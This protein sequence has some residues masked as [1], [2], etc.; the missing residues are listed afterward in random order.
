MKRTGPYPLCR[1]LI[2]LLIVCVLITAAGCF[3]EVVETR[4]DLPDI[5]WPQ[6]P[7]VPR[8][9]F[10]NAISNPEDFDIREGL[11]ARIW[12]FLKGKVR[13][14]IIKPYGI[15]TDSE[16]RLY[17][18]DNF[19]RCVHVFH[20][21]NNEYYIFPQGGVE[22]LSPIGIA[23]DKN[24]TIYVSD[25]RDQVVKLFKNRGK[26]FFREIG[27]G[28]L[29]RPTGLAYNAV[30][31][32]LL[33]VDTKYSEII[34]YDIETFKY[35]GTFGGM[36]AA[37][38]SFNNPTHIYTDRAGQIY[39]SDSLNFR[40]QVFRHDGTFVRSFGKGGDG[41]G[42]FSRPKGVAADSDGNI[43]V[44]D[45]LF[46][47]VQIFNQQGELLMD[48]GKTGSGY[49]EFWL[50]SGIFIDGKDR[51]YVSDSYN[52]RVQIFQYLKAGALPEP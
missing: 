42:Y 22:L 51:I 12:N 41:P 6:R 39:I 52:K 31:Q 37:A 23:I 8:I 36:G 28:L 14:P 32:E 3:K 50:P 44:V 2:S 34:R 19:S 17:V 30:S 27:R 20:P 45:A 49:G 16:G 46:D 40:I 1:R 43:Y 4:G 7:D 26:T 10:V 35:K 47:N 24:D 15:V 11:S 18:V 29:A 5:V 25:S 38:G 13:T 21:R 33:V 48:F 9:R